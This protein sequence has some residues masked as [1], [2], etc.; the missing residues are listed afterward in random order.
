MKSVPALAAVIVLLVCVPALAEHQVAKISTTTQKIFDISIATVANSATQT[1]GQSMDAFVRDGTFSV[2]DTGEVDQRIRDAKT[3]LNQRQ[4]ALKQEVT[5]TLQDNEARLRADVLKAVDNLP[6][7]IISDT[8]AQA[9]KDAV[10]QQLRDDIAQ[11]RTEL[12]QQIDALKT[13]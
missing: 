11:L 6:Q 10:L 8:A 13:K 3:E 2:F 5:Q 1:F 7:R 9:I 4:D 12:Q